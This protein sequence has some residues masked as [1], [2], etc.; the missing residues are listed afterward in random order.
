MGVKQTDLISD[1]KIRK[2]I[3][4]PP[5]SL[6]ICHQCLGWL[7]HAARLPLSRL[8]KQVLGVE[9]SWAEVQRPTQNDLTTD[10]G[11]WPHKVK[12]SDC[13]MQ[14][15]AQEFL[16]LSNSLYVTHTSPYMHVK[17]CGLF[18]SGKYLT[19]TCKVKVAVGCVWHIYAKNFDTCVHI[20]CSL[21]EPYLE[22]S[23]HISSLTYV[24]YVYSAPCCWLMPVILYV[25][26]LCGYIP[27][28]SMVNTWHIWHTC[29]VW[30]AYLFL[31]HMWQ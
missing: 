15:K 4:H 1:A 27:Y 20:A 14:W 11:S 22:I 21:W 5:V 7:R 8:A 6:L 2:G 31:A 10:C 25:A 19:I 9:P 23:S 30:W 16:S 24:K 29:Q 13:L 3:N 26:Y 17:F 12:C 28:I 18:A